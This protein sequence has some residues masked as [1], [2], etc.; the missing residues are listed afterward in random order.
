MAVFGV[1]RPVA[2]GGADTASNRDLDELREILL[3]PDRAELH[4]LRE[5]IRN[6]SQRA[7]DLSEVLADAIVLRSGRDPRLTQALEP[8]LEKAIANSVRRDPRIIAEALFPVIAGAVRRAVASALQSLIESL[9]QV[10]ETS[11]S[12]RSIRWRIEAART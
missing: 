9:N 7:T 2:T 1:I 3:G 6:R 12:F 11:I 5:R 10:V 8:L 4:E